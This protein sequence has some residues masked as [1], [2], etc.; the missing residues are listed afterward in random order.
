MTGKE[1]G[2]AHMNAGGEAREN[3]LFSNHGYRGRSRFSS[4]CEWPLSSPV[5]VRS[6]SRNKMVLLDYSCVQFAETNEHPGAQSARPNLVASPPP[7]RGVSAPLTVARTRERASGNEEVQNDRGI[8]AA[9]AISRS[10]VAQGRSVFEGEQGLWRTAWTSTERHTGRVQRLQ[11]PEKNHPE[12]W[13]KAT[14]VGP[15]RAVLSRHHGP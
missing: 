13:G 7:G 6:I 1:S 11:D 12:N 5:Y 8:V 4:I 2:R 9:T 14:G 15:V 3:H 10:T